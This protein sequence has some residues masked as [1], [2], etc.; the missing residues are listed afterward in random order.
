MKKY[1]TSVKP[2][3]PGKRV[4]VTFCQ[5]CKLMLKNCNKTCHNYGN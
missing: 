3:I 2:V 5:K 4:I 1:K